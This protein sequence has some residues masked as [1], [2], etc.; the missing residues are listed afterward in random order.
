MT[1]R[2]EAATPAAIAARGRA[3]ACGRTRRLSDRDG[4]R[5]WRRREQSRRRAPHLR[6]QRPAGGSSADRSS[7]RRFARA[8][9]GARVFRRRARA[10]RRILARSADA[11]PAA[12]GSC[13][14][15]RDRRRGQRRA[16]RAVASRRARIAGRFRR[17]RR[18]AFGQPFRPHLADDGGARRRR[19]RRR[20]VADPRR[21]RVRRWESSR[22]SSPSWPESPCCC[23]RAA[24]RSRTSRACCGGRSRLPDGAA[25]RAPGTL[26]DALRAANR[27]GAA[28]A[29]RAARR[30]RR[31]SQRR[32][33]DA[34]VLGPH[35]RAPRRFRGR[36]AQCARRRGRLRARPLCEP[37]R[38]S[39]RRTPM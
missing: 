22:R 1:V 8:A 39:T 11:D 36:L 7:A 27:R 13:I 3:S 29:R 6:G 12:H 15:F 23:A 38:R 5:A 28:R 37:A 32:D 31:N 24:S 25:P 14:G 10:G 16:A 20:G 2:I 21:R 19:S 18:G 17:R 35:R 26:P 4:L 9:L 34:A 30:A 33:E